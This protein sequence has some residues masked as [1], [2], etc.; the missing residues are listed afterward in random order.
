LILQDVARNG[1]VLVTNVAWRGGIVFQPSGNEA[2]RE[3]SWLDWSVPMSL[4]PDGKTILFNETREG[5]GPNGSIYIRGTDGSPAVRLGEGTGWDVSPDGRWVLATNRQQ[6]DRVFLLPTKAG[7]ART[8]SCGNVRCGGGIWFPDGKRIL[9]WGAEPDRRGRNWILDL[10]GGHPRAIS[11][12][13][14]DG[15]ALSPD[16]KLLANRGADFR[17][18]LYPVD[19]GQPQELPPQTRR[20]MPVTWTADGGGLYLRRPGEMRR[21][22]G[23]RAVAIYR[24]DRA[25]A[26]MELW[27]EIVPSDRAGLLGILPIR[28]TPDG[29]SYAYGYHRH[30]NEL[31]VVEGRR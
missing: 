19:G 1:Q 23:S 22:D 7:E 28:I 4:S 6:P 8:I 21:P 16:G 2:V 9:V 17:V 25:S 15:G 12:E 26:R 29:R 20:H 11:P 5:G 18:V 13:G 14:T 3:L 30:L 27:K 10:Q 31:Y 24:F